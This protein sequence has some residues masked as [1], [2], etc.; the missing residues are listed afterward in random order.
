MAV[1]GVAPKI[2]KG[3]ETVFITQKSQISRKELLATTLETK[4]MM[5]LLNIPGVISIHQALC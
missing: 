2:L 5:S 4:L 1:L 3:E